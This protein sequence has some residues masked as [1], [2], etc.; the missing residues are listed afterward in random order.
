MKFTKAVIDAVIA[1]SPGPQ[2]PE[3]AGAGVGR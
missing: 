1:A 3:Q 2:L